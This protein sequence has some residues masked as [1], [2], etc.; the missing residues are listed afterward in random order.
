MMQKDDA[1]RILYVEDD[2]VLAGQTKRL[3]EESDRGLF[4]VQ[5][6]NDFNDALKEVETRR[7]DLLILDVYAGRPV[8]GGDSAGI[9]VLEHLRQV[10]FTPTIFYTALPSGVLNIESP[11][12]K[13]IGKEGTGFEQLLNAVEGFIE[14]GLLALNRG[15]SRHVETIQLEYME[16]FVG[17]HW[18]SFA[19]LTDKRA[20]AYLVASRLAMSLSSTHVDELAQALGEPSLER[21]SIEGDDAGDLVHRMQYYIMPPVSKDFLAGDIIEGESGH[22]VVLTPSCDM[23]TGRNVVK[24][25][26]VHLALCLPLR[27]FKEYQDWQDQP[28]NTRKREALQ[29]LL[30]NNRRG[31]QRERYH[32]LPGVFHIP[33]LVVDFQQV[34]HL[35]FNDLQA[36]KQQRVAS[37]DSPFAEALLSR[38][39][40]YNARLGTPD[41]DTN[42][43]IQHLKLLIRAEGEKSESSDITG[44]TGTRTESQR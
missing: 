19:D 42:E 34:H 43:V 23:V 11:F 17:K 14:S 32:Y 27:T 37:L 3:F 8:L 31:G 1:W 39:N 13:V 24:A 28:D 12:V 18:S 21:G 30:R 6:V 2:E 7:Y 29:E 15:L 10:R 33:H 20:L 40:R 36:L 38:Y 16:G 5:L 22:L 26:F 9:D 35:P 25:D 4:S 44:R 41:I